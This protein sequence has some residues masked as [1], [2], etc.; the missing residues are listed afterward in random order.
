MKNNMS[1]LEKLKANFRESGYVLPLAIVFAGI[2]AAIFSVVFFEDGFYRLA[3]TI[4]GCF[5]SS[6]GTEYFRT[7]V[8]NRKYR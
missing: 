7:K 6:G 5:I 1:Q 8:R 2:L 4:I 3:G